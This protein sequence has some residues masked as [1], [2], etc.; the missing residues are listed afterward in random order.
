VRRAILDAAA[1]VFAETGIDGASLDDVA[2]A[3]GFSK[4]AVYSNF[5]GKDDLILALMDER[6]NADLSL[7]VEAVAAGQR[8]PAERAQ[9]LGDALT[10]ALH[11]QRQWHLLF[12]QLWQRALRDPQLGERFAARR[13]AQRRTLAAAIEEQ[14][15]A[16]GLT[17][18]LTPDH[19]ATILLALSNGLAIEAYP[20]AGVV[21]EHLFGQVLG[22]L[23][24]PSPPSVSGSQCS[25]RRLRRRAG[26][27]VG[28]RSSRWSGRRV[29]G[30]ATERCRRPSIGRDP[31]V[32]E[33]LEAGRY[34]G[35]QALVNIGRGVPP[36]WRHG[37]EVVELGRIGHDDR[38]LDRHRPRLD[39]PLP[40]VAQRR[41]DLVG[42]GLGVDEGAKL[43]EMPW[44]RMGGDDESARAN[45]PSKL[46]C[47]HRTEHDHGHVDGG[48][49]ERELGCA[50]DRVPPG[51]M[52]PRRGGNGRLG[53][54]DP[55]DDRGRHMPRVAALAT[56]HVEH[57]HRRGAGDSIG[58]GS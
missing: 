45:D 3:A 38:E 54:I 15:A 55:R 11:A 49:I 56:T 4:G 6:V 57:H 16:L 2:E 14:T 18:M 34:G 17:P 46:T 44:P 19:L 8:A 5:A 58:H 32:D 30:P 39:E 29:P 21:P 42:T 53:D 33:R 10:V 28:R 43:L 9:A 48:I 52:G 12:L 31:D 25:T 26:V 51:R 24:A 27:V 22:L 40:G 36:V 50:G 20:R 35:R 1:E 7:G 37:K 23:L 13:H 41:F 47:Q